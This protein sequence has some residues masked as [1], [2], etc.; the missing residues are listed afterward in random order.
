VKT[1]AIDTANRSSAGGVLSKPGEWW[2]NSRTFLSEVRNELRRVTWPSRK[3][4]YATTVVVILVST[5][6]GL[7][8]AGVDM[9]L[10]GIVQWIFSLFGVGA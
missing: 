5:F 4:V 2:Q 1:S 7:Y 10:G 6:F 3:E 9:V 8:L